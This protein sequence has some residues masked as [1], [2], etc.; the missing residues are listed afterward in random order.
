M[1]GLWRN[2]L[3]AGC[4]YK[5][6]VFWRMQKGNKKG[7]KGKKNKK[8]CNFCLFCLF[9]DFWFQFAIRYGA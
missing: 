9:C 7:K 4:I 1:E 3:M 8:A 6:S 5:D 2:D